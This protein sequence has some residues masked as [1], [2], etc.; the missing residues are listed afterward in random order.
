MSTETLGV[1]SP[2]CPGGVLALQVCLRPAPTGNSHIL[3][4][5][6][7]LWCSLIVVFLFHNCVLLLCPC[8]GRKGTDCNYSN[9][10]LWGMKWGFLIE[11]WCL[12]PIF[13]ELRKLSHCWTVKTPSV[14]NGYWFFN[15]FISS[16]TRFS[17]FF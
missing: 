10:F 15:I 7:W 4:S 1:V 3:S 12:I 11:S 5:G 8:D 2:S 16:G 17:F 13:S 6:V 14:R 9:T